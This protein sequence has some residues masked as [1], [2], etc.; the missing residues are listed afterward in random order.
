[1][2]EHVDELGIYVG[3][4]LQQPFPDSQSHMCI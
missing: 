4:K 2:P 3:L 1:M